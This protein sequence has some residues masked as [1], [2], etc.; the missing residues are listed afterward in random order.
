MFKRLAFRHEQEVRLGTYRSDVRME[1]FDAVGLLKT[2]AP[3]VKAEDVLLSPGRKGVYVG[4][5]ISVH[6]VA[7]HADLFFERPALFGD[8][9]RVGRDPFL[10]T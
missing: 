8:E 6:N 1:F 5:D 4:A 3:G 9:R 2:P 7:D 10:S